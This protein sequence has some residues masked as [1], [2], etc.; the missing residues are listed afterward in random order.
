MAYKETTNVKSCSKRKQNNAYKGIDYAFFTKE[1][2]I[3]ARRLFIHVS[4]KVVH[5]ILSIHYQCLRCQEY[6]LFCMDLILD[7]VQF[8]RHIL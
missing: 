2:G 7:H 5:Y 3:S 6:C 4:G 1:F 8:V